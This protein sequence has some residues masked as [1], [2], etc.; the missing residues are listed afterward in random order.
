MSAG[1][2]SCGERQGG[3]PVMHER[4]QSDGPVVPE[5]PSNN[6]LGGAAEVVEERG[7]AKGNAASETRPGHSAGLG[8]SSGLDRVR[9]AAQKDRDARFTALLHHVDVDRLRAAYRALNPKAATGVD[10][11]TWQEYGRDLEDNLQDL[12]ARLHRGAYRA[13][14]SRRVF[15]PKA[16]GRLRPLGVA[17]LE[18]KI[19]QR[20]VV[21]VLNAIYEADFLGF[22][23]G[24][25]P[26][27]SQ[28]RCAGRARGRDHSQEGELGARRGHPRLLFQPRSLVAGEVYRA[29]DRGQEG[30]A[31]D[32]EMVQSR[33]H[34][35]R[36]LVGDEEGTP[37][38]ASVST[39]LA[40]VY[41]HYVFDLWA[42]QWDPACARRSGRRAF[43]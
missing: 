41:L 28:H 19:V 34:R 16:D 40:N 1:G 18:D 29:P 26:G 23:Y 33:G 11:V 15:I 35:G 17:A 30:P 9:Q 3:N 37:Q 27:R 13:K 7:P 42:H 21:E 38:G 4:G 14:P 39:L 25:R 24:F 32:P 10:G 8:V 43:R 5:K 12:H 2:G 31:P 20:A 36:G 6:A 22:S